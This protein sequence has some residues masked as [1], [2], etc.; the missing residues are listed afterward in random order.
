MSQA[1]SQ[2]S[3]NSIA[4]WSILSTVFFF[5]LALGTIFTSGISMQHSYELSQLAHREQVAL[6]QKQYLQEQIAQ[7]D[8]IQSLQQFADREGFTQTVSYQASLETTV[9][10]AQR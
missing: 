7:A 9:Q 8:S 3:V 1:P 4:R 5:V 2:N 10:V 6:Q